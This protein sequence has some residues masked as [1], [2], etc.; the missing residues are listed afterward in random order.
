MKYL[1]ILILSIPFWLAAQ[2]DSIYIQFM[3]DNDTFPDCHTNYAVNGKYAIKSSG[4]VDL[5]LPGMVFVDPAD[6]YY[7]NDMSLFSLQDKVPKLQFE[8]PGLI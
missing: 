2:N 8:Y 3:H 6:S 4:Q 5:K 7:G 1:P